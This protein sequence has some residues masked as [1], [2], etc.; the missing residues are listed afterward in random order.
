MTRIILSIFVCSVLSLAQTPPANVK[1]TYRFAASLTPRDLNEAAT[2]VK[3]VAEVP[4][5]SIDASTGTLTFTGSAENV[6]FAQWALSTIDKSYDGSSTNQAYTL[7][8]GETARV[9]F[10]VYQRT[11]QN[12]QELLTILRTVADVQHVFNL[13]SNSA[14]VLR[15]PVWSID[16]AEWIIGQIDQPNPAKP[17]TTEREFNVGG[18]DFRG[19]GHSARLNFLANMTSIRQTSELLTVLRT[20]GEVQKIFTFTSTHALVLRAGDSDLQRAE[21]IIRQLDVPAQQS[22]GGGTFTAPA[23]DDVTRIFPV[24]NANPLWV[25]DAAGSLRLE[26]KIRTV[27]ATTAPATIIVRG[28]AD[29]IAAAAQ[30]IT[31]HNASTN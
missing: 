28:A 27:S 31:A 26:L 18:P 15:G 13:T 23:G 4:Q 1:G 19:L 3:S 20:V 24:I 22:S 25:Q 6:D 5:V 11:P 14:I 8:T 21:W 7:P 30:W 2:V 29:Q 12:V 17:D 10:L 16:F 9:N